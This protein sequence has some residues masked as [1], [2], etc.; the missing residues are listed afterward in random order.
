MIKIKKEDFEKYYENKSILRIVLKNNYHYK[1]FVKD[2][3]ETNIVFVHKNKN[4]DDKEIKI[5]YCYIMF[6]ED[7]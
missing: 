7:V 4:G 3:N 2:L 5:D 1:G 6:L